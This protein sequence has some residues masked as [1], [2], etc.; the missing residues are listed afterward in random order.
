MTRTYAAVLVS[1][2]HAGVLCPNEIPIHSLSEH[3]QQLAVDNVDWHTDKLY[4][5]RDILGNAQTVFPYSQ[6]YFNVN[7]HPD[8]IDESVPLTLNDLPIYREGLGPSVKQRKALLRKYHYTYHSE[9]ARTQKQFVLDGHST[10]TGHQDVEGNAVSD[11]IILS[12]WQ[13]SPLDP[14]EGIRTAPPGYL[15]TYAEELERRSA[16][17][18]LRVARNTTYQST[19]GH[20][21]A[22]HGWDGKRRR[23]KKAPLLLQETNEDLYI[24]SGFIDIKRVE[25]LRRIFAEALSAML[26]RIGDTDH[27]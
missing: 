16:S 3:Q 25:E 24:K 26:N 6:V 7:R 15:E 19:Y 17:L 13:T 21:M 8:M 2:P 18:H 22:A 1:I 9:I 20:V 14:P 12:D 10:V 23:G 27:N 11:D 4:D 5:F